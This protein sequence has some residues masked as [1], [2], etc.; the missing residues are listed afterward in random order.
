M[1]DLA[2]QWCEDPPGLL[3]LV[4]VHK[5]HLAP[6]KDVQDEVLTCIGELHILVSV[7]VGQT[8]SLQM[9]SELV[10]V[11]FSMATRHSTCR[12]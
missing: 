12:M 1:L 8:F 10:E 3:E 9:S 2:Q 4:T 7:A 6:T 11:S 5:V